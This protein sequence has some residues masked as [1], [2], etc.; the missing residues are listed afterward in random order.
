MIFK[1][2]APLLILLT[3]L[4]VVFAVSDKPHTFSSSECVRCHVDVENAPR[5]IKKEI[6]VACNTCHAELMDTQSH[7]TD[8]YPI[9]SI[10][11]DMPLT[12]GRLTCLTCHYVHYDSNTQFMGKYFF[13]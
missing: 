6:T 7:P 10:P 11:A 2:F 4:A 8:I 9:S 5:T 3:I 12:D 13:F 1:L